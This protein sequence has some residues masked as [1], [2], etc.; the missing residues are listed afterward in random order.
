MFEPNYTISSKLNGLLIEIAICKEKILSLNVLPK[1]EIDLKQKA[2]LRMIHSSTA[3]EGNLLGLRDVE[4]VLKGKSVAKGKSK[5]G[6]EVINYQKVMQF[7]DKI[8]NEQIN[9]WEKIIFNIHK[10]TTDKLLVA[11]ESGYY[12]TG[13]VYVVKQISG[14]V[15][16]KAPVAGEVKKMMKSFCKWLKDKTESKLSPIVIAGIAHH[17]LVTIHPFADGNGRTARALAT[18]VLYYKNYDIKKMFALEDYYNLHRDEYYLAIQEARK[19]KDLTFWLEYFS[20]GF[21][22]ELRSVLEKV[23]NFALEMKANK[24]VYLSKRQRDILDFIS[25]N[26]KI[27]RSDVVDIASVSSKTAYRELEALRKLSIIERKGK[28]PSSHYVI[29]KD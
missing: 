11:K 9:D 26:R 4:A 27:F 10:L 14:K 22:I 7:I 25:I 3:I 28:G 23:E 21:L 15:V 5:D 19:E 2:R 24:S 8:A 6:L 1:R 13:P 12:R 20:Q 29:R 16:Y 17:E 18:L